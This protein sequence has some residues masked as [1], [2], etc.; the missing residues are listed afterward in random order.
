MGDLPK[1][2]IRITDLTR[3]DTPTKVDEKQELLF[4]AACNQTEKDTFA[5]PLNMLVEW[6]LLK[7][8]ADKSLSNLDEIGQAILDAKQDY[9]NKVTQN[10]DLNTFTTDGIWKVKLTG[11][12]ECHAPGS[13]VGYYVIA[14][15]SDEDGVIEQQARNLYESSGDIYHRQ[16]VNGTWTGWGLITQDMGS[17]TFTEAP[18]VVNPGTANDQLATIGQLNIKF[19]DI[20][21]TEWRITEGVLVTGEAT[22]AEGVL[23]LPVG[24]K[25]YTNDSIKV[26]TTTD[27]SINIPSNVTRYVFANDE[28]SLVA[29]SDFVKVVET[30]STIPSGTL[31]YNIYSDQYEDANGT[32]SLAPIGVVNNGSFA[33]SNG[34]QFLNIENLQAT[35]DALN[36]NDKVDKTIGTDA[37]NSVVS[38]DTQYERQVS[39]G[40]YVQTGEEY[41]LDFGAGI[42]AK[43]H[44]EDEDGEGTYNKAPEVTVFAQDGAVR[45]EINVTP[46]GATLSAPRLDEPSEI[47]TMADLDEIIQTSLTFIG[48]VSNAQPSSSDFTFKVGNLWINS[49][50]MPTTFPVPASSIRVWNGTSWETTTKTYTASDFDFV[51]NINDN[52]GYYWFGGV[53]KVMSTDMDTDYFELGSD[54]KWKI[55]TNVNLPGSPTT[56]T[57]TGN[58]NSTKIATTAFVQTVVQSKASVSVSPTGTSTNTVKYIIV[59][60]TEYQ[61]A[62]GGSEEDDLTIVKNSDDKIQTVG[63]LDQNDNTVAIKVWTGAHDDLPAVR[64]PNTLYNVTDD[65][66]GGDSVYTKTEV[67]VLLTTM[68]NTLY[69]VG[70]VYI[71]TQSTCPLAT[72]ISNSTWELVAQD[73]SIQGSST[74]HAAGTTIEA[75]LPDHNHTVSTYSSYYSYAG[76]GYGGLTNSTNRTTSNA[77]ASNPIY[78]KSNTVQPPAYVVNVWRRIA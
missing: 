53:W 17:P 62:G 3:L 18:H 68:L 74:N 69:P 6:L 7:H 54:G 67:D 16:R 24:S 71:G 60:G 65:V 77:S 41:E 36:V 26:E 47:A 55:K 52:E 5:L 12:T 30:P 13:G 66:S 21:Q 39:A 46:Q 61:L 8:A 73:R 1:K 14:V 64:D 45:T 58:D 15:D 51:R 57:Q 37:Q 10:T 43:S 4:P 63:V 48:Y 42:V 28:G 9:F 49:D 25:Y 2:S 22:Y 72:L 44:E 32:Y 11:V 75:G 40:H 33:A 35:L 50:T 56:T 38:S 78:G 76:G 70:S 29:W 27:I 59:N 20:F 31:I 19:S 34:I 23:T